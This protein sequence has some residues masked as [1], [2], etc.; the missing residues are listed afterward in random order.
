MFI[1]FL[2]HFNKVRRFY[3][4][5]HVI[6]RWGSSVCRSGI[7]LWIKLNIC[8]IGDWFTVW[9][10][11]ND[12]HVSTVWLVSTFRCEGIFTIL[13]LLKR[14]RIRYTFRRTNTFIIEWNVLYIMIIHCGD[15]GFPILEKLH[16]TVVCLF[17][18]GRLASFN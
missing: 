8:F 3:L 4:D 11:W 13:N 5:G 14:C 2:C 16:T 1:S 12:T 6:R 7:R 18:D 15:I 9:W 17:I 10:H